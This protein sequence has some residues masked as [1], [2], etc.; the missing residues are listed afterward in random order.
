MQIHDESRPPLSRFGLYGLVTIMVALIALGTWIGARNAGKSAGR[1]AA[2]VALEQIAQGCDRNQVQ[3][4][5]LRIRARDRSKGATNRVPL[6]DAYFRTVN[7]KLTYADNAKGP[8]FL[9]PADDRCFMRLTVEGVW[10][11]TN[12]VTDP[13]KLRALCR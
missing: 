11:E 13:V 12:P 1:V 2:R 6:A 9:R 5:Y 3:R 7:C 10:G 8:V 4:A